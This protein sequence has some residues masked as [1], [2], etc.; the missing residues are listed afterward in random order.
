M[1]KGSG[2]AGTWKPTYA[3]NVI[4]SVP[5]AMS[6][7]CRIRALIRSLTRMGTR[8]SPS[9]RPRSSC[10]MRSMRADADTGPMLPDEP[11]GGGQH[12]EREGVAAEELAVRLEVD[13]APSVGGRD[14]QPGRPTELDARRAEVVAAADPPGEGEQLVARR[15]IHEDRVEEAVA[16]IGAGRD[17]HAAALVAPEG[18]LDGL[19]RAVLLGPLGPA[20][21]HAPLAPVDDGQQCRG[22]VEVRPQARREAGRALC[23]ERAEAHPRA[24]DEAPDGAFAVVRFGRELDRRLGGRTPSHEMAGPVGHLPD[25]DRVGRLRVAG[26]GGRE[27][28]SERGRVAGE[29]EAAGIVA[30]PPPGARRPRSA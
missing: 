11:D 22:R 21:R 1:P 23:H 16:G 5:A 14:L 3:P 29:G 18:Q 20:E 19:D 17:V 25:V 27:A 4:S 10:G 24:V 30:P 2:T 8:M 26:D 13:G 9:V 6:P 28:R 7:M 15:G 12:P